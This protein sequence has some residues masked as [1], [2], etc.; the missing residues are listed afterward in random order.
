MQENLSLHESW[1]RLRQ[2]R[3]LEVK[4]GADQYPDLFGS[5]GVAHNRSESREGGG[6]G[7]DEFSLGL[8]SE[9][10]VDLWGRVGASVESARLA[11]DAGREDV[12]AAALSISGRIGEA[13]IELIDARQQQAQ[14]DEQL[15]INR[16]LL[17]LIEMRFAM[18]RAS[19]LDV[20]QQ[21]QTV[22]A[23]EGGLI[24]VGSRQQLKK[25]QLALLSGQPATADL[26]LTERGYPEI[27]PVPPTG[28]PAD[29]LARRPDIRAAGLRL[30]GAFWQVAAARADRLPRLKLSGSMNYTSGVLNA[31]LDTWL[32]RLAGSLA[33]PIV[34]GGLRR[35]EVE[36]TKAVV[37][38][39]LSSY[40]RIVLTAICEVEDALTREQEYRES[41][42]N[43]EQQI[44]LTQMACREATWRY[45][46]GLSDFLPVLR[47]QINLIT[48]Q[49]DRIRAGSDLL[50]AR[51]ALYKALGGSW[52]EKLE[53]PATMI[54]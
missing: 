30:Q 28:L 32:L 19:A 1:A 29:L 37:D 23:I 44:H 40:R 10:E 6:R 27:S 3:A 12:H 9:Y 20:Y 21:N 46:N 24:T 15:E 38:E 50:I 13:W 39:R 16:K 51:I 33:G 17:E 11:A 36:R 2:A 48:L 34:D 8:S 31:L 26:I 53:P 5:A 14:L 35:A 49:L 4:A 22:K 43:I 42:D 41:L 52:P 47:E 25:H 54:Q 18:S 7:D 45:L